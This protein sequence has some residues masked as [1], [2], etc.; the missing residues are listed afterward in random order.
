MDSKKLIKD[1]YLSVSS[2]CQEYTTHVWS[3]G[4]EYGD[5]APPWLAPQHRERPR[6]MFLLQHSEAPNLHNR[7][8]FEYFDVTGIKVTVKEDG[9]LMRVDFEIQ[10]S[11]I[12]IYYFISDENSWRS[13]EEYI[14]H[15]I[16][17]SYDC[18]IKMRML[19]ENLD[20]G[21]YGDINPTHLKEYIRGTK[22][23][24]LTD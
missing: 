7:N 12:D 4:W 11:Y 19:T 13:T 24:Q 18:I 9:E 17:T 22:L 21:I 16:R 8:E 20:V 1:L 23:N 5:G 10:E 2:I 14:L 6:F 3:N 15:L